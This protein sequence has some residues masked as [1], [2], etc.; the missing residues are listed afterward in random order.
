MADYQL[1]AR[2]RS[3]TPPLPTT[4]TG[5]WLSPGPDPHSADLPSWTGAPNFIMGPYEIVYA[6]F[7]WPYTPFGTAKLP[8][9][10]MSESEIAD[11]DWSRWIAKKCVV[12]SW[13]TSPKLD[14]AMRCGEAWK[15]HGLHFQGVAFTWIKTSKSTGLPIGASGPRPRL[16]KPLDEFLL[17]YSTTPKQRTFPLMS[18]SVVQHVFAPKASRH[19]S[20]PDIFRQRIV[21]LLGDRKRVE[22]FA[23]GPAADGWDVWGDEAEPC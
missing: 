9:K 5:C 10:C 3:A 11:F 18:E 8:Y 13:A 21:E 1:E 2:G 19:S 7:P 12:F 22:L 15:A 4:L 23:R 20:K 17:A 14:V 16:V 6:D